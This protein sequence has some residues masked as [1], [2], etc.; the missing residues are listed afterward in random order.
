[1]KIFWE[2]I[3]AFFVLKFYNFE[4]TYSV[5]F[6]N[7]SLRMMIE[8]SYVF[9]NNALFSSHFKE[10]VKNLCANFSH[11]EIYTRK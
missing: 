8:M 10:K 11:N 4:I 5:E 2:R 3:L 1:M 7:F 6:E 9:S